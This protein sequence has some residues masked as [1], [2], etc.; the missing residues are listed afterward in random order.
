[1]FGLPLNSGTPSVAR[2]MDLGHIDTSQAATLR[3]YVYGFIG[4]THTVDVAVNGGAVL[5]TMSG[6]GQAPMVT[7]PDVNVAARPLTQGVNPVNLSKQSS[8]AS[9][10]PDPSRITSQHQ[11]VADSDALNSPVTAGTPISVGGFT[12]SNV[13]VA[14]ISN[15]LSPR[16]VLGT[17][18]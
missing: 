16:E 14:D 2:Q 4:T 6:A 5:A 10:S 9:V 8:G 17:V 12:A 11:F 1:I 13:R 7:S 15:P 18:S 3:V